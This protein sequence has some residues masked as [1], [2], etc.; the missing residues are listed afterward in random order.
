MYTTSAS[1]NGTRRA[2]NI[3]NGGESYK[4]LGTPGLVYNLYF[5]IS[6]VLIAERPGERKIKWEGRLSSSHGNTAAPTQR[7]TL[8][9]KFAMCQMQHYLC[10]YCFVT[11]ISIATVY[12]CVC[13]CVVVLP[14]I[15]TALV[16][17]YRDRCPTSLYRPHC[18]I[19]LLEC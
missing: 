14:F 18:L 12:V 17:R 10:H 3:L 7:V 9:D 15:G 19:T 1:C 4:S 5:W 8:R 6:C 11:H 2:W 13:V 16:T